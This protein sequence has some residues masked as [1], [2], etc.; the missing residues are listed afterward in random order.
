MKARLLTIAVAALVLLGMLTPSA[1]AQAPSAPAPGQALPFRP[2]S[3][4]YYQVT[5]ALDAHAPKGPADATDPFG[6][7]APVIGP[8]AQGVTSTCGC[9]P[10]DAT[11]AIGPTE[12]I[13]FI[14][15]NV[16]VYDRSLTLLSSNTEASLT[17]TSFAS[18]DGEV[19]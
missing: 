1:G 11:G 14:N 4:T 15:E 8:N 9:S 3:P 5:A 18:G 13:E 10:S 7:G 6:P 12:Y 2:A 17:G 19:M 16:G